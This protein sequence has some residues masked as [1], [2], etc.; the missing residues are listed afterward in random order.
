M[1]PLPSFTHRISPLFLSSR[2]SLSRSTAQYDVISELQNSLSDAEKRLSAVLREL[3]HST[4]QT[5]EDKAAIAEKVRNEQ[6]EKLRYHPFSSPLPLFYLSSYL[7]NDYLPLFS[8]TTT[9]SLPLIP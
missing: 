3:A 4:A 8:L 6:A 5:V 9:F 7:I 2:L 1:T